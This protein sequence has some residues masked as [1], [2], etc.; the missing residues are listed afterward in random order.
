MCIVSK[1]KNIYIFLLIDI[2]VVLKGI[3]LS[4]SVFITGVAGFLGSHLADF[5]LDKGFKVGG[6][7]N[8]IGGYKDNVSNNIDFHVCDLLDQDNLEK[9]IKGYDLVYH[10]ACLPYEG[11]SVFSPSLISNNTY[12][13]TINAFVAS[14]KGNVKKFIHCSSMA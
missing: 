4:K 10:T 14:I 12:Q 8:L 1:S 9:H 6:V 11:L 2:I 3:K 7:D 13:I 5:F